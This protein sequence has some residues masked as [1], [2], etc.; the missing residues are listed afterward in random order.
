MPKILFYSTLSLWFLTILQASVIPFWLVDLNY[1]AIVIWGLYYA[2]NRQWNN[3]PFWGFWLPIIF[4]LGLTSFLFYSYWVVLPYIIG[5]IMI[6]FL[7]ERR[8]QW[9]FRFKEGLISIAVIFMVYLLAMVLIRAQVMQYV[10]TI[11]FFTRTL[12]TFILAMSFW[13]YFLKQVGR[14]RIR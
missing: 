7:I 12:I 10:V 13:V 4:G 5:T 9:L 1:L 3:Y 8:N 11:D 6:S 2:K 14:G